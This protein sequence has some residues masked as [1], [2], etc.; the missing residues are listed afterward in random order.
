MLNQELKY[1]TAEEIAKSLGVNITSIHHWIDSGKLEHTSV[2][3]DGIK[4]FSCDNLSTFAKKYNIAVHF[5][6]SANNYI[7]ETKKTLAASLQK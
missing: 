1:Y 2:E 4:K 7:A 3:A 5:I 6:N